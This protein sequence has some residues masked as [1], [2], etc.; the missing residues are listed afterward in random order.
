[1]SP[2]QRPHGLAFHDGKLYF[3]AE[4]NKIVGRYDPESNRIDWMLGTG[5]GTSHMVM[6]SRDGNRLFTANITG[7]SVS[8]LE[9]GPNG[10]WN[11]TAVPVGKGP[12][13]MDLSPDGSQLWVAHSRDGGVSIVDVA[14]KKVIKTFDVKTK[15]SN[16]LKFTADGARVLI[17]DLDAGQ[18]LVLD[19]A[20]QAEVKRLPLGKS[21]EG[22]L[23]LAGNRALVAVNGDNAIAEIDLKTLTV[24]RRIQ[25]GNGPDGMAWVE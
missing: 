22:I 23:L 3:T 5:Q 20:S 13:G 24:T 6:V 9:R 10:A 25:P 16:R 19:A 21:P 15:R 2:L 8:I 12:E 17:T 14:S 7:D 1:M 11:A 4:T 18:L